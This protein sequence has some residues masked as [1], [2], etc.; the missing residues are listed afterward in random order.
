MRSTNMYPV[1]L[2]TEKM[3]NILLTEVKQAGHD[4]NPPILKGMFKDNPICICKKCGAK[5]CLYS[6]G[7]ICTISSTYRH[8]SLISCTEICIQEII[9]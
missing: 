8:D 2:M 5:I 1:K 6:D 4:T 3:L 7:K 9:E